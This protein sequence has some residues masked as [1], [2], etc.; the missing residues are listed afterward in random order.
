MAK[1]DILVPV[2]NGIEDAVEMHKS[3]IRNTKDYRL[4][5]ID[6]GSTDGAPEYFE[7]QGVEVVR[8][9][10]NLGF[11]G[12][13]NKGIE[14][15]K[16]PNVVFLNSDVILTEGW[17]DKLLFLKTSYPAPVG[18]I[19]PMSNFAGGSQQIPLTEKNIELQAKRMEKEFN[20]RPL[21]ELSFLSFFCCLLDSEMIKGLGPLETYYPGGYEDNDY[22]VRASEAGWKLFMARNVFVFH[23]GSRTLVREF[24]SGKLIFEHRM[25]YFKKHFDLQKDLKIVALYRVKNDQANFRKSLEETSKIVD[26]IYVWD[27]NSTPSLKHITNSFP[28]VQKYYESH[29]PFDEY[30]DR[31]ILL[32]WAKASP[33]QWALALDSDELLESKVTY[34]SLHNL[35]KVPDPLIRSFILYE[36]TFWFKNFFR[37]DGIWNGQAHDRLYKLN[38]NQELVKG[39]EKG[40]HCS[41]VPSFPAESRRITTLRIEHY[42]YY[43]PE[44]RQKKYSFYMKEDTDKRP[45]LIGGADYAHLLDDG[46]V[47]VNKFI[48]HNHFSL[49][50][51]LREGEENE[52]SQIMNELWGLP[53]EIN[54]LIEKENKKTELLKEIF[55]ANVYLDE[56]PLELPDKRNFLIDKSNENWVFFLDSDE[57]AEQIHFFRLMMDAYPDGYLFYVKNLQK[58]GRTTI[59]ENVRFFRKG[60][61]LEFAGR[62]HETVEDSVKENH[63]IVNAPFSLIHFGYLKDDEFLTEKLKKYYR[64]LCEELEKNP[65][66]AKIH[67]S[68]ALHFFNEGK[69]ELGAEHLKK[70]VEYNPKF[71]EAKKELAHYHL[72]QGHKLFHEIVPL[73]PDSHP[74]KKKLIQITQ[75]LDGMVEERLQIGKPEKGD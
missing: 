32:S 55:R 48:P 51:L 3:L 52:A 17:L 31:S 15:I 61:G 2:L 37:T 19:G 65:E 72:K 66:D 28:K 34:D 23:K 64:V 26:A 39:T 71:A 22:C 24:K 14:R 36:D 30:R 35:I 10:K 12:A 46:A 45:E 33:Y 47:R 5:V 44:K 38:M 70:A 57:K 54:L 73:L 25:D 27:D 69:E 59:S 1:T 11:G 49:N 63:K 53:Q 41:T 20:E 13:I 56:K 8:L 40:F 4:I 7:N 21:V 67:F 60:I 29:L 50:M 74:L 18:M 58:D 68:L 9:D 43:N 75:G 62:I 6:N 16:A 42:G